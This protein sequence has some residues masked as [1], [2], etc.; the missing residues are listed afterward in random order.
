MPV[1]QH[2]QMFELY[3]YLVARLT[4]S[5]AKAIGGQGFA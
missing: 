3:N 4:Q 1:V 5:R 2:S